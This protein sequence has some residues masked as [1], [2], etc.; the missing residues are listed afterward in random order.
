VYAAVLETKTSGGEIEIVLPAISGRR[1]GGRV[2]GEIVAILPNA[3][4][5]S[6]LFAVRVAVE[7]KDENGASLLRPGMSLTALVPTG[8][9][10]EFVTV[11]KDAIVRTATGEVVYWDND[12]RSAI[13]PVTR[14]FAVGERVAVKSPVL[15]DGMAVVVSG[16]ERMFPGQE[17]IVQDASVEG[18]IE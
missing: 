9:P 10:G 3:D 16:N 15:R 6:R 17:L 14:L 5:L 2:M 11:S 1:G 18:V 12:G 7:A 13:A 8:E 4:S